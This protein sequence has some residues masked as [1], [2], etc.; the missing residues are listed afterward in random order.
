MTVCASATA[1]RRRIY[2]TT[3]SRLYR[4]CNIE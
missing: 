1:G 4:L 2:L 3:R